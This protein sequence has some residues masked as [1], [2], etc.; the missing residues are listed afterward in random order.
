MNASQDSNPRIF[1]KIGASKNKKS[2]QAKNDLR[3]G[4]DFLT[5]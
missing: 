1:Q 3:Q 5:F 4:F 2:S